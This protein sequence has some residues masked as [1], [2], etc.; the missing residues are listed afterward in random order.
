[1]GAGV[2]TGPH[3]PAVVRLAGRQGFLPLG[4]SGSS[5]ALRPPSDPSR[6]P[7]SFALLLRV[8]SPSRFRPRPC[9]PGRFRSG[10]HSACAALPPFPFLLP[11]HRCS[12]RKIRFRWPIGTAVRSVS[13]FAV[14]S[15]EGSGSAGRFRKVGSALA[16]AVASRFFLSRPA[17][18]FLASVLANFRPV[19]CGV[20]AGVFVRFRSSAP[21]HE[22]KLSCF[23]SRAKGIRPVDNLYIGDKS[24][25]CRQSAKRKSNLRLLPHFR[26]YLPARF[27]RL[28]HNSSGVRFMLIPGCRS[29]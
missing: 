7:R 13:G 16:G 28:V 17:A 14:P 24:A 6:V 20:V 21:V 10:F 11:E 3:F 26:R 25:Q 1:M 9:G 2:A 5:S 15:P 18:S 23:P 29:C 27:F 12:F 19:R 8:G 4:G 22:L